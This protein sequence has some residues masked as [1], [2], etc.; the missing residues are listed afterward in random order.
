M[1]INYK[2]SVRSR[3]GELGDEFHRTRTL[4]YK[5]TLKLLSIIEVLTEE[6]DNPKLETKEAVYKRM[7]EVLSW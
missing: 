2:L 7:Y 4:G 6:L 3:F 5:D 1:E